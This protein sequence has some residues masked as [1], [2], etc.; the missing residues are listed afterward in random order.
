M[1]LSLDRNLIGGDEVVWSS[2]FS[3]C[4]HDCGRNCRS[5][6][7][8]DDH[9]CDVVWWSRWSEL[10]RAA[11]DVVD[12]VRGRR[13]RSSAQPRG[14][15]VLDAICVCAHA[16]AAAICSWPARTCTHTSSL[17]ACMHADLLPWR[18]L[19]C[20]IRIGVEL[21]CGCGSECKRHVV[22]SSSPRRVGEVREDADDEVACMRL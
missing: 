16:S 14:R 17:F 19:L 2:S 18:S 3:T 10:G 8:R 7:L 6:V 12:V 15:S 5:A 11:R 20:L 4:R 21:P 9:H 1:Y 22:A 13:G